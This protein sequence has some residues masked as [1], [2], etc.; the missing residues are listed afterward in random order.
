MIYSPTYWRNKFYDEDKNGVIQI[1]LCCDLQKIDSAPFQELFNQLALFSDPIS[2]ITT[3]EKTTKSMYST[4]N[5]THYDNCLI[6]A[7]IE[8]LSGMIVVKHWPHALTMKGDKNVLQLTRKTF[9][10]PQVMQRSYSDD[11]EEDQKQQEADEKKQAGIFIAYAL[12]VTMQQY[13]RILLSHLMP[14]LDLDS[15]SK[16]TEAIEGKHGKK[17]VRVVEEEEEVKNVFDIEHPI[18]KRF[19]ELDLCKT[20]DYGKVINEYEYKVRI[21][22]LLSKLITTLFDIRNHIIICFISIISFLLTLPVF[23][24]S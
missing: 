8:E 6:W 5:F 3:C 10:F 16:Q 18:A 15:D 9:K 17:G 20:D 14:D 21:L 22:I 24:A 11:C 1:P 7:G 13:K 2:I 23:G 12:L 4:D 19:L